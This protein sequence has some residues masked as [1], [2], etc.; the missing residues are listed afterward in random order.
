MI[1]VVCSTLDADP[2]SYGV[3]SPD[4]LPSSTEL[5]KAKTAKAAINKAKKRFS[6]KWKF[7]VLPLTIELL[8]KLLPWKRDLFN[9]SNLEIEVT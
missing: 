3:D 1:F 8:E 5:V 4:D 2:E 7:E 6:N 9:V